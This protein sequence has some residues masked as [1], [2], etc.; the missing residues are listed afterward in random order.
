MQ[1]YSGR[2]VKPDQTK[3]GSTKPNTHELANLDRKTISKERI[4]FKLV[5][6]NKKSHLDKLQSIDWSKKKQ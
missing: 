2:V 4:L 3:L 5:H 1:Y 6:M